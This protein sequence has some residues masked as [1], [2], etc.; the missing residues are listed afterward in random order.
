MELV[1]NLGSRTR[2]LGDRHEAASR[3]RARP[4]TGPELTAKELWSRIWSHA[5]YD[6]RIPEERLWRLSL[7]QLGA[8]SDRFERQQQREDLLVGLLAAT[9]ANYSYYAPKEPLSALD[10]IP[11][12]NRPKL[13]EEEEQQAIAA[14][15]DAALG[16]VAIPAAAKKRRTEN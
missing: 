15:I 11:E 4:Y 9:T 14:R 3:G 1:E 8:L 10:F 16:A 5:L 7:R 2:D 13:S 6:L 12:R